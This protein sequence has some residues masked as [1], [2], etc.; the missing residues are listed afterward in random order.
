[1]PVI[2]LAER[3]RQQARKPA[4]NR[5]P[6]PH[7]PCDRILVDTIQASSATPCMSRWEL[8][9]FDPAGQFH[10]YFSTTGF[11]HV[12]LW[13][14][15]HGI[16]VLTPSRLTAGRYEAF[17]IA[18]WKYAGNDYEQ[19]AR[20]VSAA[21]ATTLPPVTQVI[22]Y[23]QEYAAWVPDG[24]PAHRTGTALAQRS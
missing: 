16:S 15:W 14:P 6:P 2:D 3:R 19:L 1:M 4:P 10:L 7:A 12:Q 13:N 18:G 17:P 21:F 24:D 8:R 22:A 23:C 5:P 11:N 20:R 9:V